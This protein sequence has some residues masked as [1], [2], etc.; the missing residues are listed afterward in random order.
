M[1]GWCANKRRT[2]KRVSEVDS[3]HLNDLLTQLCEV[4]E[5]PVSRLPLS[6]EALTQLGFQVDSA[7][8]ALPDELELLQPGEIRN[9][10][11]ARAKAW[12]TDLDVRKV[13]GSTNSDLLALAH[14]GS[15]DG[16]IRMAE[17][18]T[19]GRGRRG[20]QWLSPFG[21]NLA[22]SMGVLLPLAPAQLGGLSLAVGLAVHDALTQM[23][24]RDVQL[25]WPNDVLIGQAKLAGIL[26]ELA[27]HEQGTQVVVG[28]G[29][30]VALTQEAQ[31]GIDQAT[32]DLSGSSAQVSRNRLSAEIINSVLDYLRGFAVSGFQPMV[33]SFNDHHAYHGQTCRLLMGSEVV[34]GVVKGVSD[35]GELLLESD[36][37][38]IRYASGEV[39][40]RPD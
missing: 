35:Q 32:A 27:V 22:L 17:L 40:L 21:Q 10:L 23:G 31:Q 18:Q 20:R 16:C 9:L 25:K 26:V 14:A 30:N 33:T 34:T 36:G 29:V 12:L 8:V 4:G 24:A 2:E 15:V 37:E 38:L 7:V 13:A 11:N 6:A 5:L 1:H 39:S 3:Q 19:A 28:I